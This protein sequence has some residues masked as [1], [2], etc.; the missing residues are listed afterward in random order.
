M[1]AAPYEPTGLRFGRLLVLSSRRA[2]RYRV[3][4]CLCDCG[5]EKDIRTSS[6]RAGFTHSCGCYRSERMAAMSLRH[7]EAVG[8][9]PSSEW[10]VWRSMRQRCVDPNHKSFDYYGGRGIRVCGRW[11]SFAAFLVDMGRRPSPDYSI[12]RI[13]NDGNYEPGNCRWATRSEQA[14]NRRPRTRPGSR[15][16]APKGAA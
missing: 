10:V 15:A 6:L 1:R 14:K 5:K 4:R 13:N 11:S 3:A 7:G 9:T 16:L 2:G 12:D 8:G